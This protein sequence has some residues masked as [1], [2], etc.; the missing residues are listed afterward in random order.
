MCRATLGG[1]AYEGLTPVG[2]TV[3]GD[4]ERR[5]MTGA[6]YGMFPCLA[7]CRSLSEDAATGFENLR[8]PGS[9]R[10]VVRGPCSPDGLGPASHVFSSGRIGQIVDAV[11]AVV[12]A[13]PCVAIFG[14]IGASLGWLLA[15]SVQLGV[16]LWFIAKIVDM[17]AAIAQ[18]SSD[19]AAQSIAA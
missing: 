15:S 5:D 13:M 8:G 19:Q 11:G 16:H 2:D 3:D 12:I 6:R 1:A 10:F 9:N 4:R 17:P 18:N 7:V 14:L